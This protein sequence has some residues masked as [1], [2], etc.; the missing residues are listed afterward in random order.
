MDANIAQMSIDLLNRFGEKDA[1]LLISVGSKLR[2]DLSALTFMDHLL[3]LS[4]DAKFYSSK[5]TIEY[6][7]VLQ[8]FDSSWSRSPHVSSKVR[9]QLEANSAKFV[10]NYIKF[11]DKENTREII[12]ILTGLETNTQIEL[13]YLFME[14][15]P[16]PASTDSSYAYVA[17]LTAMY[18]QV[19]N[20]DS[21]YQVLEEL[22]EFTGDLPVYLFTSGI[23][24]GYYELN[25]E[26]QSYGMRILKTSSS[27][28]AATI[29]SNYEV[30]SFHKIS[31]SFQEKSFIFNSLSS[32]V[33]ARGWA[34]K[35]TISEQ[36][37][38]AGTLINRGDIRY[39]EGYLNGKYRGFN[40]W[41]SDSQ[42][43]LT[44]T[45]VNTLDDSSF[46]EAKLQLNGISSGIGAS[47]V[48]YTGEVSRV[49]I[50]FDSVAWSKKDRVLYLSSS[51]D[52]KGAVVQLRG[53]VSGDTYTGD[54][55]VAGQKNV[56][57]LNLIRVRS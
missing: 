54:Y 56:I 21:G 30:Y 55:I 24:D 45:F 28:V 38:I 1:E 34:L 36:G 20:V 6:F 16:V 37:K 42:N 17:I 52:K 49:S 46:R 51:S 48:L 31:Y 29:S 7:K 53:A 4:R 14:S 50:Y 13:A 44:G 9:N 27:G 15:V 25:I 41:G 23:L 22:N 39:F 3:A 32:A 43:E 11:L 18:E 26:G 12:E 8:T 2:S 57:T 19:S 5:E 35:F 40:E 47:L 10:S 33:E